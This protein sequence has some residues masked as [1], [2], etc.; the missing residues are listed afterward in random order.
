MTPMAVMAG[1]PGRRTEVSAPLE[2]WLVRGKP[3]ETML[4]KSSP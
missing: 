2:P 1:M 4:R 3:I